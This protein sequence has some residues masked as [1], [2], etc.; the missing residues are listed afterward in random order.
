MSQCLLCFQLGKRDAD[1]ENTH[2]DNLGHDLSTKDEKAA[3][4]TSKEKN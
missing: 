2:P 4:A 1:C 3:K